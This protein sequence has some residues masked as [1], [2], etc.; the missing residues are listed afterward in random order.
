MAE[1][2][3]DLR[4]PHGCGFRAFRDESMASDQRNSQLYRALKT[5]HLTAGKALSSHRFPADQVQNQAYQ[6]G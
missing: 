4:C 6:N 5:K 1:G 3:F 2:L